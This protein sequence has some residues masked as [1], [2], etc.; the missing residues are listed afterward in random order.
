MTREIKQIGAAIIFA[1]WAVVLLIAFFVNRGSDIGQL[2]NLAV[3]LGSGPLVGVGLIDSVVGAALGSASVILFLR[4]KNRSGG[5]GG[6]I[7]AVAVFG[8]AASLFAAD[9][10]GP[11][12]QHCGVG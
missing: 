2:P 3:N 11:R 10:A 5:G 1:G 9:P 8:S 6:S 12:D 7:F 4:G